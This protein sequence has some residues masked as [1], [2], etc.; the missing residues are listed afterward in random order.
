MDTY[1]PPIAHTT[2]VKVAIQAMA[3]RGGLPGCAPVGYKNVTMN[4]RKKV[5][6]D[7]EKARLVHL[8]FGLVAFEDRPLRD[9]LQEVTAYGLVSRNGKPM[10]ISS[11]WGM[12]TNPFYAGYVRFRGEIVRG[13]HEPL[14]DDQ[15]FGVVQARLKSRNRSRRSSSVC[16]RPNKAHKKQVP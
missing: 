1:Y 11:F 9:I 4:Y 13:T 6:I 2:K 3:I 5:I 15:L 10:G 8:A 14:V 7:E 12:L 16:P